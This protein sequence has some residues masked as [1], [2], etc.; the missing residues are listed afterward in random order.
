MTRVLLLLA[1]STSLLACGTVKYTPTEYRLDA[2]AIRPLTLSGEVAV[3]NGQ[4]AADPFIVYSYMGSKMSSD[5]HSITE[6]M[7]NQMR[8]EVK[9][10]GSSPA[11][12][13]AKSGVLL[14]DLN[15]CVADGVA[16]FLN[17]AQVKAYLAE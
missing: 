11:G 4:P 5:L 10:H 15:G 9:R 1:A 14:Q 16:E 13:K 8:G 6:M 7:A 2:D 3:T 12:G 17:D